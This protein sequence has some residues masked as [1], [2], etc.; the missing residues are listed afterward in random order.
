MPRSLWAVVAVLLASP[1]LVLGDQC[2]AGCSCDT[3][4]LISVSCRHASLDTVP[5]SLDPL[6]QRLDLA[7]NNLKQVGSAS[8]QFHPDLVTVDL[9]HNHIGLV[10]D[11]APK[12]SIR[13]FVITEKAPTRAFSWLKAATTAATTAYTIK[14]LC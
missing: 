2:E 9:A 14:T 4:P 6:I 10:Q 5:N 7:H 8:F 3:A 12:S 1:C 11:S 13:R